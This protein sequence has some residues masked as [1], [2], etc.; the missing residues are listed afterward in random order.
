LGEA[1]PG[2]APADLRPNH[3]YPIFPHSTAKSFIDLDEDVQYKDIV[4]AAQE[5]FDHVE[6]LKRYSTVGM[7]PTQGKLANLN[8]IRV[9]SK[10]QG[11]MVAETGVTTSRPFYHPVPLA[12]LAGRGSHPHRQTALH[13]RLLAAGAVLMPAGEWQRPAY[14]AAAGRSRE[15]AIAEEVRAVRTRVGLIDVSTLGKLE[16]SGPDAGTFVERVY[17]GR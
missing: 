8:A 10:V 13:N 11:Q 4:N 14:Y 12:H 7:G 6:L 17:T 2:P 15:E 3:P 9:L 5:G 16:I 1:A